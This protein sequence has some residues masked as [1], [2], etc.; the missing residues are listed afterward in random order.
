MLGLTV[1]NS[2]EKIIFTVDRN[3]F[4][5][6]VLVKLMKIARLE[7]LIKKAA[8]DESVL[9]VDDEIKDNWWKENKREFLKGIGDD[10]S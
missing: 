5:E 1:E 7:Y 6:D 4:T 2:P 9:K 10:N 3:N 8:F